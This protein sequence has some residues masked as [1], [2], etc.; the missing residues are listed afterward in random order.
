[1]RQISQSLHDDEAQDDFAIQPKGLVT[2]C[3]SP[4]EMPPFCSTATFR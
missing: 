1:M 4:S 2:C 3:A